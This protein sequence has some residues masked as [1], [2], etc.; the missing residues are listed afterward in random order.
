MKLN[1]LLVLSLIVLL[2][3]ILV[4]HPLS[5]LPLHAQTSP[6][7]TCAPPVL[8]RLTR[9]RVTAGETLASIAQNY[10]LIP[11]TLMGMN[12]GLRG[13]NVTVGSEIL[14]PPY[15]GIRVQLAANQTLKDVAKQY[16]V[17]PDVLFEVNG[18][19]PNPR[20]VFVPGVNWS[21]I[22]TPNATPSA[23]ERRILAG[24]PLGGQT[25]TPA[26][27]LLGYGWVV[28]P[29][30]GKVAFH[31]GVDLEAAAG[32]VVVAVGDG[33]VAFAG[34]QGAYGNL[35]VIN[36]AEGLQTRYAQLGTMQVKAGQTVRRGQ[37]IATVG[38]SGQPSSPTPHL[39]F[40]VRSRSNLGWVAENPQNYFASRVRP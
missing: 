15:N 34:V 12:P 18:C 16:N 7:A 25:T 11:A 5:P 24:S 8:S 6:Q 23:Q 38:T 33:T 30:T 13:G 36:H 27:E 40:E 14:V 26:I 39:H 31:S 37:A 32:T 2:G 28:H 3:E 19:Q 35:V 20:V 17:R 22:A 21:P 29:T 9:H 1:R 4:E 10:E